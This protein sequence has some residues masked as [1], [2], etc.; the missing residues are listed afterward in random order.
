M[1]VL[2]DRRTHMLV[3]CSLLFDFVSEPDGS[4]ENLTLPVFVFCLWTTS[5][6]CFL[7]MDFGG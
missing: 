1:F 5:S 7:F 2:L 4:G 6:G 3:S